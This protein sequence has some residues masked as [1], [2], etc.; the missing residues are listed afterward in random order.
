MCGTFFILAGFVALFR[1]RNNLKQEGTNIR[2]LEKLMAK[3]GVFA[4]R[5]PEVFGTH[6]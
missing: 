1:I 5:E 3:I 6:F 2:K 4:T